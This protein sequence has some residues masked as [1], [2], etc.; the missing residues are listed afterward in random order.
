MR[1]IILTLLFFTNSTFGISQISNCGDPAPTLRTATSISSIYQYYEQIDTNEKVIRA[2]L[3][4]VKNCPVPIQIKGDTIPKEYIERCSQ[5]GVMCILSGVKAQTN[6]GEIIGLIGIN[7]IGG[8]ATAPPKIYSLA[9][10]PEIRDHPFISRCE[11]TGFSVTSTNSTGNTVIHEYLNETDFKRHKTSGLDY[12]LS[13]NNIFLYSGDN[14]TFDKSK[15]PCGTVSYTFDIRATIRGNEVKGVPAIV[16]NAL[17]EYRHD[18][19]EYAK[20]TKYMR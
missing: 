4:Y 20:R 12:R 18:A 5:S 7:L 11:I 13:S 8:R 6:T 3:H 9:E 15:L 1:Y 2:V 19:K 17:P 16:V 10:I 14:P